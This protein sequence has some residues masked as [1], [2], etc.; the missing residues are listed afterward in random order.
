MVIYK[1]DIQNSSKFGEWNFEKKKKQGWPLGNK[2]I[3]FCA[4]Q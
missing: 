4:H 2:I 3:A 1:H